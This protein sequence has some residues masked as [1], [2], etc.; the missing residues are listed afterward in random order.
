MKNKTRNQ[1]IIEERT[2]L[3]KQAVADG[4]YLYEVGKIFDKTEGRI[5]QILKVE[6]NKNKK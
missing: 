3:I 6:A 2:K 1:I 5:S 4:F